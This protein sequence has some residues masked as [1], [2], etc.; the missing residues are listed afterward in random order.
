MVKLKALY[1]TTALTFVTG[2]SE[3]SE[4]AYAGIVMI[5]GQDYIAQEIVSNDEFTV[6]EQVGKVQK[7]VNK[8]QVSKE[9]WSTNAFAKGT[10]IYSVNEKENVYLIEVN[11][12]E[13]TIL[14]QKE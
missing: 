12:N 5:D 8:N 9:D 14:T 7:V 10:E 11:D 2:C 6:R 4:T 1:I 3:T 13:Y